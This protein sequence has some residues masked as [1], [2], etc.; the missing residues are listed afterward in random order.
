M[1]ENVTTSRTVLGDGSKL[2]KRFIRWMEDNRGL[3]L[4]VFGL[5]LSF[6]FDIVMQVRNWLQRTFFASPEKHDER[7]QKIQAKVREWNDLPMDK[8]KKPFMCTARP[9]WLSLSTTFFNKE[10]C[11]KVPIP[12]YDILSLDEK[13][14]TVRVEPMVSV[15]DITRF[16]VPRGYTLAVTLEIADATLG[17]LAC[18]VGMT[19]YS[20]KVGLY[21]ECIESWEVVVGDGSLVKATRDNQYSDLYHCLPWSHGTLGFLVALELKIIKVKPYVHMKYIPIKGKKQ[22]CD[23]IREESGANDATKKTPD[24][25]EGTVYD[26]ENA[27]VMIGNFSDASTTEQRAKINH[28]TRWYK[29]PFYK[30]VES[31]LE[32]GEAEEYI[33]LREYLLRHDK[34][35]FWVLEAMIPF[36][37]NPLFL[38]LFGWMCPPKPAF[39]KLTTTPV[40]RA[41]TFTKQVFQ[42]IVLPINRLEDQIDVS[43]KLFDTYPILIYPCRIYDSGLGQ[44]RAPRKDQMTPNSNFAMFNDLGV[45]G[46][47]R[48]VRNK[49]RYDAV[50]AMR[51]MEAFTQSV[52]GYPFLYA[53]IFMTR[54]EFEKMFD[55]TNY[56]KVRRK[57]HAIGAFPHLYDKVKPEIDVIKVGK[58]FMDPL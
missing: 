38:F 49:E 39:M 9:N 1:E 22:Y 19:T 31:F 45:Y 20:H 48:K 7:V 12:L 30:H 47:P 57:Y 18:G 50:G 33:P 16:L 55:L 46:V 8:E 21:Q 23:F 28:I 3:I 13:N 15:G 35:I 53:D 26:K 54:D 58:D 36:C 34:A 10:A 6:L 5:P 40:V 29:L 32:K 52:G 27:V 4:T 56:E 14:M 51:E 42:D 41:M 37:N 2:R 25:L 24:Y 17:G 11:H 43:E 44:L